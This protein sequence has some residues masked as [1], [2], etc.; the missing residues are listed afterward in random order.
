MEMGAD[1]Y[2]TKPFTDAELI[3]AIKTRLEKQKINKLKQ[4]D[5]WK[6]GLRLFPS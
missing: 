5:I 1:D 2:I 4:L 3:N 6:P